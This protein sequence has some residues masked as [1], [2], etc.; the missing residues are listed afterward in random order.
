MPGIKTILKWNK[1]EV[2]ELFRGPGLFLGGP[3]M[4]G[5]SGKSHKLDTSNKETI[6]LELYNTGTI[7]ISVSLPNHKASKLVKVTTN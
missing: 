3:S 1:I 5:L 2:L 4:G 6:K 7:Y